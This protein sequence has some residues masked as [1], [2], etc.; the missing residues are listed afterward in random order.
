MSDGPRRAI[1][2][3]PSLLSEMT[4]D[5]AVSMAH[6]IARAMD[7]SDENGQARYEVMDEREVRL[8]DDLPANRATIRRRTEGEEAAI[9]DVLDFRYA[10][11][12]FSR[13][14]SANPLVQAVR[15]LILIG[16]NVPRVM[17]PGRGPEGSTKAMRLQV[18]YGAALLFLIALSLP[19]FLMVAL[20]TG[21]EALPLDPVAVDPG[22]RPLV[23]G[24]LHLAELL[25][26]VAQFG[27]LALASAGVLLK[28]DVKELWMRAT[29]Y[30][31]PAAEYLQHGAHAGTVKGRLAD[32]FERLVEQG[33]RDYEAVEI[34][35]YSMGTV[36]A[37]DVLMP[38]EGVPI[39]RRLDL[40]DRLVTF[41]TPVTFV[42]LFFPRYFA[43][44][45]VPEGTDFEWIN[46]FNAGDL[47]ATRFRPSGGVEGGPE[48]L[49]DHEVEHV[50]SAGGSGSWLTL[51][52]FSAHHDYWERGAM[53]GDH[54]AVD[55][56]VTNRSL[57]NGW[58]AV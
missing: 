20:G 10:A 39:S 12:L 44:R 11:V 5:S 40:V 58:V 56:V 34:W 3:L 54:N 43:D 36:I 51:G 27:A 33:D 13:F 53:M 50:V 57:L 16:L 55:L 26:P 9:L 21:L 48:R 29:S 32:L 28:V 45:A 14:T 6:R 4:G 15:M 52:G 46:V 19:L 8:T 25:W 23:A 42:S 49:P 22:E 37:L 35:S 41:G 1:I 31:V 47:L 7:R 17:L 18:A 24:A 30:V 2:Y 38:R